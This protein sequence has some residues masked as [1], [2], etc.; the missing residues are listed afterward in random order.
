VLETDG[1]DSWTDRVGNE[2]LRRVKEE[3]NI[4]QTIKRIKANWSG[5]NV[6]TNCFLNTRLNERERER[7]KDIS[8]GKTRKKT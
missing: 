4:L 1:E 7:G 8:D 6:H 5:H 3:R 2:V